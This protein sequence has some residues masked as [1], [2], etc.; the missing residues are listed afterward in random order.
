MAK[1]EEIL[2]ER[3]KKGLRMR[4]NI[5]CGDKTCEEYGYY[6]RCYLTNGYDNC[7]Y[8]MLKYKKKI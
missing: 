6:V 3:V 5:K 8:F 7:K 4:E 1:L 2:N